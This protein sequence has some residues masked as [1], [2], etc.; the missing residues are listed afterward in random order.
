MAATSYDAPAVRKAL[1]LIE[2]LSRSDTAM[3]ISEISRELDIN[4]NM[5]FRLVRVLQE[6]G[7]LIKESKGAKYRI[8]SFP[9]QVFG[10]PGCVITLQQAAAQP[11]NDLWKK[12]G[13]SV[14]L[15]VMSNDAVLF[16]EHLDGIGPV[17]IAGRVGGS[18]PLHC[19]AAG[20]ILLA[21][22]GEETFER[23][24]SRGLEKFT[25]RTI[26][27]TDELRMHLKMVKKREWA[28]DNEE[29]GR[30]ILCYAVPIF[31]STGRVVGSI[32]SSVTTITHSVD[33]VLSDIAPHVQSAGRKTSELLGF[34]NRFDSNNKAAC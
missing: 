28:L 29:H 15:G 1:K 6:E 9:L 12:I 24:T 23:V 16:I 3:G 21:H 20:K 17:R 22:A 30:G 2:L 18:Y 7:W 13:E 19:A 25:E 10:R 4:R 14:Y 8:S 26:C 33:D 5:V 27:N 11:L 34:S 31:D 32:G